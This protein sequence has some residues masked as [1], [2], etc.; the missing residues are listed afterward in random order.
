MTFDFKLFESGRWQKKSLICLERK[1]FLP[2][3]G[4]RLSLP[5][6]PATPSS[7]SRILEWLSTDTATYKRVFDSPRVLLPKVQKYM[8]PRHGGTGTPDSGKVSLKL[9]T[10]Y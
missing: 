1:S 7:P 5:F 8:D 2:L 4:D 10:I 3:I 9:D 6:L